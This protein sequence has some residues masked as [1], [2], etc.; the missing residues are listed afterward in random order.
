MYDARLVLSTPCRLMTVANA[1]SVLTSSS[2][3]YESQ[4]TKSTTAAWIVR[5]RTQLM[6]F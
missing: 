2:Q 4:T 3:P 5:P 1:T 6:C